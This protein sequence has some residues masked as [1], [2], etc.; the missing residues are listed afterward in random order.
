[1]QKVER[2]FPEFFDVDMAVWRITSGKLSLEQTG[3]L[4]RSLIAAKTSKRPTREQRLLLALYSE[5]ADQ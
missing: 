4:V 5:G 2:Q 1:M 3:R